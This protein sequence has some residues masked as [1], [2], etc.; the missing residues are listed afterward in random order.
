MKNTILLLPIIL[1]LASCASYRPILNDN[2][3]YVKVGEAAAEKDIDECMTKADTFLEKQKDERTAKATGRSAVG[4]AILGGI[5]GAVSGNGLEGAVGGAAVGA[6]ASA[7]GTYAG[8]KAKD[9]L[10]PDDLKQN[11]VSKCLQNKNYEILG[12][13]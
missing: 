4:G 12:W 6:G 13:K 9:K 3:Q 7:A 10:G 11:Y 1:F 2:A 5:I 8:E